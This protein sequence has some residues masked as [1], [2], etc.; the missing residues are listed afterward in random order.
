MRSPPVAAKSPAE[1]AASATQPGGRPDRSRRRPITQARRAAS[2][3]GKAKRMAGWYR[4]RSRAMAV[5]EKARTVASGQTS[6]QERSPQS[7]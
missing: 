1:M 6:D 7:Q 5:S 2:T 3:T 4:R